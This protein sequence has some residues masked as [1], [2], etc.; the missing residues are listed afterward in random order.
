M[1]VGDDHTQCV[2]GPILEGVQTG[3]EGDQHAAG[4]RSIADTQSA[5]QG[6]QPVIDRVMGSVDQRRDLLGAQSASGTAKKRPVERRQV[7]EQ[8][9]DVK[10][11]AP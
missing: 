10:L 8:T 1:G 11:T 9:T 3:F 2:G 7:F 5:F 4:L 6:L